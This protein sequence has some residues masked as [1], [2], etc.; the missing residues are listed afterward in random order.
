MGVDLSVSSLFKQHAPYLHN[1]LRHRDEILY[2]DICELDCKLVVQDGNCLLFKIR[3][4]RFKICVPNL[5][6]IRKQCSNQ[7]K[8][9]NR[10][11]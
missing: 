5:A 8:V 3:I 4:N 9:I 10:L 7:S 6:E 2:G 1:C 11:R